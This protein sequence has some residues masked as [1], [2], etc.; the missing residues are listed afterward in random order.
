[1]FKFETCALLCFLETWLRTCMLFGRKFQD[2]RKK[3]LL[4]AHEKL[5]KGMWR[6]FADVCW[7]VLPDFSLPLI[8]LWLLYIKDFKQ[9]F[10]STRVFHQIR[11]FVYLCNLISGQ[12]YGRGWSWKRAPAQR[13]GN[14]RTEWQCQVL[15]V[16]P[17][18]ISDH[19]DC[20]LQ[21]L[22]KSTSGAGSQNL[23]NLG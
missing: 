15:R 17:S 10:D 1:M 2:Q 13:D 5:Q 4:H 16:G 23:K 12:S 18:R 11:S 21:T 3:S 9:I 6:R 7:P 8:E 20:P 22:R 14:F 19:P